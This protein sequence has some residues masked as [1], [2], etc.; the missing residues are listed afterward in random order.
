[1][2]NFL[3]LINNIPAQIYIVIIAGMLF[4]FL[5]MLSSERARAAQISRELE[6]LETVLSTEKKE[7]TASAEVVEEDSR[8][9]AGIA[10]HCRMLLDLTKEMTGAAD[11]FLVSDVEE[12]ADYDFYSNLL[13]SATL[14]GLT[15]EDKDF[16]A[17]PAAI[18]NTGAELVLIVKIPSLYYKGLVVYW[19]RELPQKE[20][21]RFTGLQLLIKK[22]ADLWDSYGLAREQ[23]VT[24]LEML[25]SLAQVIDNQK[26]QTIGYSE[27]MARY[28]G[29]IAREMKLDQEL[30]ADITLAAQLSNIGMLSAAPSFGADTIAALLDNPRVIEIIRHAQPGA[31]GTGVPAGARVLAVVQEFLQKINGSAEMEPLT[32]EKTVEYLR[33]RSGSGLDAEAVEAL[34][35]WF[36]KKRDNPE[37]AGRSLGRCR[38]MRCAPRHICENCPADALPEQNC[39]EAEGVLCEAHGNTCASCFVYTE[40]LARNGP[41]FG[42]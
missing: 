20:Y 11:G 6:L 41:K 25:K 35:G 29:I 34:L 4:I 1:M 18:K 26:P 42:V 19:Y 27:Q 28:A 7:E 15:K 39:W 40:Y 9:S 31:A 8:E 14:R 5:I 13:G 37:I 21:Y 36:A 3:N 23:S 12:E 16:F 38:E 22:M 30:I 33:S 17:L 32:Y 2:I 10:E 24:I